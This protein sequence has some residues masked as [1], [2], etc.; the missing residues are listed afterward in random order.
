[1]GVKSI[2]MLRLTLRE[3]QEASVEERLHLIEVILQSLKNDIETTSPASKK[4]F[5]V[6][7]FSLGAEVHID[8]DQLYNK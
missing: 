7:K 2:Q 8:R 5:T 4:I 1:M 6:R 3:I